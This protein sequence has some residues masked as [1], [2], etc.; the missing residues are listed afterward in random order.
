MYLIF[1]FSMICNVFLNSVFEFARETG[2][3]GQEYFRRRD[4]DILKLS[5]GRKGD[6]NRESNSRIPNR[7][8]F[9][10]PP[11]QTDGNSQFSR[12]KSRI[13]SGDSLYSWHRLLPT[14]RS[15]EQT[16]ESFTA[17][18]VF[19]FTSIN[20]DSTKCWDSLFRML[21]ILWITFINF[22]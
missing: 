3:D 21:F 2:G 15:K 20:C 9:S 14:E 19:F 10:W 18:L 11:K 12:T 13:A 22:I 7:S 16:R 6:D 8:S 5:A 17:Q 4:P 1:A